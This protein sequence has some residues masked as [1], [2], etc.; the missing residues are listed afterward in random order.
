MKEQKTIYLADDDQDDRF[1][2]RQAIQAAN[3]STEII[4]V[5]NGLELIKAMKQL[6]GQQAS[7]ILMDMNMPKMNGL[8]TIAAIRADADLSA[9]P[10]VM[11]STSSNTLLIEKAYQAGAD[12]FI[13][14]PSTFEEFNQ[15]GIQLTEQFLS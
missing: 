6:S 8:E 14:K 13:T 7:L 12:S 9:V 5:E 10:V 15:L 3:A 1:F 4:E 2:L 11:I